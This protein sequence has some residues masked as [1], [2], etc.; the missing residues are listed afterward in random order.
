MDT[1]VH[2]YGTSIFSKWKPEFWNPA[3]SW[4]N[5][6]TSWLPDTLTD[7]WHIAKLSNI[8]S[9]LLWGGSIAYFGWIGLFDNKII[10]IIFNL[11]IMGVIR[12][13]VFNL[14]YNKLL[15]RSK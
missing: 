13:L 11:I 1:L 14:F 6:H 2:H 3:I 9:W 12:N 15:I 5:K 7:G 8:L 4:K 10:D